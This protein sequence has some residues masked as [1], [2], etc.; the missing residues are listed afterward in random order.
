MRVFLSWSGER[1]RSVAIVL[2]EWL[3]DVFQTVR[4]WMSTDIEMGARWNSELSRELEASPSWDYLCDE[5]K[6]N[7]TVAPF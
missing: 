1:S 3:S 7:C 6:H 4:P 5:R 2:R